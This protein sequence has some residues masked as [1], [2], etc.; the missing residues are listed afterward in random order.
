MD[1]LIRIQQ[2]YASQC[3][4]DWEHQFGVRIDTLDNPGWLVRIDLAGTS[5]E[6]QG[7]PEIAEGVGAERHPDATRWIYCWLRGN[8]WEGAGDETQLTRLLQVF[9]DWA[10]AASADPAGL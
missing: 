7:F 2:W 8:V 3:N 1:V 4:G 10:D 6:H 5:L 9:L